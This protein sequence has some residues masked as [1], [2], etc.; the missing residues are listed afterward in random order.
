MPVLTS[1]EV[2]MGI[3]AGLGDDLERWLTP[4]LEAVGRKTR[5]TWAPLYVQGLLGPEGRRSVQPMAAS[6][7]YE[8]W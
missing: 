7:D 1:T 5:R 6:A 8:E 4:F 2:D 3:S